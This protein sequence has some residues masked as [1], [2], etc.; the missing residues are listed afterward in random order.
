MFSHCTKG[1]GDKGSVSYHSWFFLE[2]LSKREHAL[3]KEHCRRSFLLTEERVCM[4]F[5]DPPLLLYIP[6]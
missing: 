3:K 2:E 1:A 6:Y 5:A 4:I